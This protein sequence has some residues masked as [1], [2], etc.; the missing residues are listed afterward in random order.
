MILSGKRDGS[1]KDPRLSAEDRKV[2][3]IQI[4]LLLSFYIFAS[5]VLAFIFYGLYRSLVNNDA[6][7]HALIIAALIT[8]AFL[9]LI[10][11]I[12]TVFIVLIKEGIKVSKSGGLAD[13]RE[14]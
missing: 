8:F 1:I 7:G 13:E 3:G 14:I 6:W 9:I 10:I 2:I 11:V 4:L 12:S 5:G